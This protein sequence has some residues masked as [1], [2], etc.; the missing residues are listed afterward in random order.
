MKLGFATTTTE[1][2]GVRTNKEIQLGA[3]AL[4]RQD[5]NLIFLLGWSLREYSLVKCA[6]KPFSCRADSYVYSTGLAM[7]L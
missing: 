2:C 1:K 6:R 4:E 5:K 3:Q 7:T